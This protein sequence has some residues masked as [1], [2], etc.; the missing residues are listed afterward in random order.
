[1]SSF[2]NISKTHELVID[3]SARSRDTILTDTT[4]F[5]QDVGTGEKVISF[6]RNHQALDLTG[7]EVL[8]GF[9]FVDADA[10]KIIQSADGCVEV[11][12]A[13]NGKCRVVIP[14][15]VY[16]YAGDVMIH[17]Y[18]KF[19][20]GR[21]LDCGVIATRL[22]RSWLDNEL[23]EIQ[24]VYVQRFEDLA[25]EISERVATLHELVDGVDVIKRGEFTNHVDEFDKLNDEVKNARKSSL[26]GE[27]NSLSERLEADFAV[28]PQPQ[29]TY[30]LR[31]LDTSA[32]SIALNENL[33]VR[34]HTERSADGVLWEQFKGEPEA[35]WT[36]TGGNIGLSVTPIQGDY[37]RSATVSVG[38]TVPIGTTASLVVTWTAPNGEEMR[39]N[40]LISV[41][42]PAH[43]LFSVPGS[44][45]VWRVLLPDDG[46]GNAL[47]ITEHVHGV[48]T[49]YNTT[50]VF[51][52]FQGSNLQNVMNA[53]YAN[54]T[55]VGQA[56]RNNAM[57]YEFQDNNGNSVVRQN[58]AQATASNMITAGI[59][60][61][62]NG[63]NFVGSSANLTTGLRGRTRALNSGAETFILSVEEVRQ[64]MPSSLNNAA[65][66]GVMLEPRRWWLRSTGADATNSVRVIHQSGGFTQLPANNTTNGFRPALWVSSRLF[67][68]ENVNF[69]PTMPVAPP[70][71]LSVWRDSTGFEW[72]V[73]HHQG[74]YT[75]LVSRYGIQNDRINPGGNTNQ[76][77]FDSTHYFTPWPANTSLPNISIHPTSRE[78][79]RT[80]W[81]RNDQVS[82]VLRATAVHANV[83]AN[84]TDFTLWTGNGATQNARLSTPIAGSDVPD[85]PVFFLS[86]TEVHRRL[87]GTTNNQRIVNII[88]AN[89]TLGPTVRYWL[90]SVGS[91]SGQ[92]ATIN[93][94]G[95]WGS[96]PLATAH[97]DLSFRPAVWVDRR[98]GILDTG[99]QPRM[100]TLS[101]NMA[102]MSANLSDKIN[103]QAEAIEL[104]EK[105]IEDLKVVT[106]F[107]TKNVMDSTQLE[108][109]TQFSEAAREA[110]SKN[111][112]VDETIDETVEL[113]GGI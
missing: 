77:A 89:G 55:N 73:A 60:V 13:V 28:V 44:P 39:D 20:D 90:R 15:Y 110:R 113:K 86:D 52:T 67:K 8:I 12:D 100:Q 47:I 33:V 36:I 51:R 79:M 9:H 107:I 98:T 61:N 53:W 56:I 25:R 104:H 41:T 85:N 102:F 111:D 70:A 38:S 42:V 76:Q 45:T 46:N 32:L 99:I 22:E 31:L 59:E 5:S 63:S 4:F 18:L 109:F 16:D 11:L 72:I 71:H 106:D 17:V 96:F 24:S 105:T 69:N 75:M 23:P 21:A 49:Q 74:D 82:P 3:V 78:R 88:R 95:A 58:I 62:F 50:N 26:T 43:Q 14:S 101:E 83:L 68:D 64:Y 30:R 103:E 2:S 93:N 80:W 10:S 35:R 57:S 19:A 29:Y 87:G 6:M 91:H 27:H 66:D 7:A 34:V 65:L 81:H 54:N 97:E 40:R 1:M 94:T 92:G 108:N 37:G 48:G 84:A 112:V